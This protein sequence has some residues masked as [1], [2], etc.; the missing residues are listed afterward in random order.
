MTEI[1]GCDVQHDVIYTRR[2]EVINLI[3][4]IL[5]GVVCVNVRSGFEMVCCICRR[6]NMSYTYECNELTR[7]NDIVLRYYG[8]TEMM[9]KALREELERLRNI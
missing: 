9:K 8:N 1:N 5:D 7:V 2:L 3:N 4:L 6:Y